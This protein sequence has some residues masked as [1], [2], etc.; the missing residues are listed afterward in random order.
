MNILIDEVEEDLFLNFDSYAICL[1]DLIK[2]TNPK[3]SIGIYGE[4]GTRKTTLMKLV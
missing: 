1:L 2:D 4:W 3:F